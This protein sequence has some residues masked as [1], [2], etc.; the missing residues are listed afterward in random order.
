MS[1]T[2]DFTASSSDGVGAK[3]KAIRLEKKLDIEDFTKLSAITVSK[4]Q[5]LEEELYRKVGTETFVIGY[6]RKYATWLGVDADALVNEYKSQIGESALPNV[7]VTTEQP[8]PDTA[9]KP[10][11]EKKLKPVPAHIDV[12]QGQ[13]INKLKGIPAWW[14]LASLVG[15]WLLGTLIFV[16]GAEPDTEKSSASVQASQAKTAEAQTPSRAASMSTDDSV[17]GD[18]KGNSDGNSAGDI[19][20]ADSIAAEIIEE[21]VEE[22]S[23]PEPAQQQAEVAEMRSAIPEQSVTGVTGN[24]RDELVLNFSDECWVEIKNGSGKI[25]FA[26][27]QT[28]ADTLTLTDSAPFEIMLGNSRVATVQ[29]NGREVEVKPRP[30]RKTLRFT[31]DK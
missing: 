25:I 13:L 8:L 20:E 5:Y 31:V 29:I 10:K 26:A 9:P 4:V 7:L 24:G 21:T 18:S 23:E 16:P 22:L 2:H 28:S 11:S 14:I 17:V 6:I 3:L 12:P 19:A 15:L 1:D 30:G 27:V